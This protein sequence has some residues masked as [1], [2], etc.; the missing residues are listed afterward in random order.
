[1][2]SPEHRPGAGG[3][4]VKS[5]FSARWNDAPAW[6]ERYLMAEWARTSELDGFFVFHSLLAEGMLRH[7][8]WSG[9]YRFERTD[10]PEE[11]RLVD[12]F[13]S[14]RPHLRRR[15]TRRR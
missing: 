5:S 11:E 12:P 7:G 15:L 10:R 9:A 2:H 6:G 14:R 13:R 4:A 1:M 3:D 8:R